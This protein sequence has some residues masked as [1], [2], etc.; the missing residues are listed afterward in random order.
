M[1]ILVF[2]I[3]AMMIA[4]AFRIIHSHNHFAP[5]LYW[6]AFDAVVCTACVFLLFMQWPG[7]M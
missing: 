7:V 2:F 3:I 4:S 1:T 5:N 6:M